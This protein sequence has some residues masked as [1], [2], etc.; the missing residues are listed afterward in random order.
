[1]PE[2]PQSKREHEQRDRGRVERGH[3]AKRKASYRKR[4][5]RRGE[6][7]G[8]STT[9]ARDGTHTRENTG[10]GGS[11]GRREASFARRSGDNIELPRAAFGV[12]V[13]VVFPDAVQCGR[14]GQH[15]SLILR[16]Q[17]E[18]DDLNAP[19][20]FCDIPRLNF[21]EIRCRWVVLLLHRDR[22]TD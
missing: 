19:L 9:S 17:A 14:Y 20:E 13:L 21:F 18:A 22:S 2:R 3:G 15:A 10:S 4:I 6:R 11:L 16:R 5:S 1:M 12:G 8:E 7:R